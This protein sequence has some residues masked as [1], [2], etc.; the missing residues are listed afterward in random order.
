[1]EFR[2][3]LMQIQSPLNM[4]PFISLGSKNR[5]LPIIK[6]SYWSLEIR[7]SATVLENACVLQ[8]SVRLRDTIMLLVVL[9]DDSLR[10]MIYDQAFV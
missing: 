10:L 9:H 3:E 8:S 4:F 1:M 5:I 2:L 7:E 6:K